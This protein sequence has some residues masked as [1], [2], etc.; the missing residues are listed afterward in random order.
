MIK[1]TSILDL[2]ETQNSFV[3]QV[4]ERFEASLIIEEELRRLLEIAEIYEIDLASV[5][6]PGV[7]LALC[8]ARRYIKGFT[9]SANTR[10]NPRD[11][12]E[13]HRDLMA[14]INA[15]LDNGFSLSEAI[16]RY[17]NKMPKENRMDERQIENAY[18]RSQRAIVNH[19]KRDAENSAI[20][21]GII[22]KHFS[23]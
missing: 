7:D 8:L 15:D 14:S 22:K 21:E 13:L 20:I 11:A 17:R 6:G 1:K 4:V 10:G 9:P 3:N 19:E 2:P 23:K 5:N 18:H 16:K 12:A